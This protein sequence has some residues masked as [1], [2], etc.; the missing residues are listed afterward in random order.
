MGR[1]LLR[2]CGCKTG[3]SLT[4][5]VGVAGMHIFSSP[6]LQ[7]RNERFGNVRFLRKTFGRYSACFQK[8]NQLMYNS[9]FHAPNIT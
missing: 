4:Q 7:A 2:G 1:L 6:V 9:C 3:H 8:R 5:G